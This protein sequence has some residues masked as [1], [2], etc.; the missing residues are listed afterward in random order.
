MLVGS[1]L[2]PLQDNLSKLPYLSMVKRN[3]SKFAIDPYII[4]IDKY[5]LANGSLWNIIGKKIG[6]KRSKNT[7]Q[8]TLVVRDPCKIYEV[9]ID[10]LETINHPYTLMNDKQSIRC[11]KV[12]YYMLIVSGIGFKSL[13]QSTPDCLED[14]TDFL[15]VLHPLSYVVRSPFS[16][17][18]PCEWIPVKDTPTLK[19]VM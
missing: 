15:V 2:I 19:L 17:S 11:I 12:M 9:K 10:V 1:T 16:L 6:I 8:C 14:R 7:T 18:K 3:F 4:K 13:T 5:K